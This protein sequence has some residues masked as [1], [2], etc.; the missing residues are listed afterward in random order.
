MGGLVPGLRAL[1]SLP[2]FGWLCVVRVRRGVGGVSRAR[3]SPVPVGSVLVECPAAGPVADAEHCAAWVRG[4]D[5]AK[6]NS[7]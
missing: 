7:R 3:G 2:P 6:I 4:E 1:G 5:C